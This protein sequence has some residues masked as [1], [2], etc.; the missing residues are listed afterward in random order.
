M[1][2]PLILG[3]AADAEFG[4]AAAWYERRAG[5]GEAFIERVQEALD[6]IGQM[7]ELHATVYRDIRRASVRRFPYSV[8]YRVLPGRIEVIAVFHDKRNPK[9]WQSRA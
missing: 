2:L 4:E 5:L 3:P 1:N 8:L 6:R 7:P 9:T